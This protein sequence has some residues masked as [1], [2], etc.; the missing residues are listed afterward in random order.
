MA[1]E[2]VKQLVGEYRSFD[3]YLA[4]G[5]F[6]ALSQSQMVAVYNHFQ[7]S[8]K[9]DKPERRSTLVLDS[10]KTLDGEPIED[11]GIL[12]PDGSRACANWELDPTSFQVIN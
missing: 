7:H 12:Q 9:L 8:G 2:N 3:E 10:R 5:Q 6:A 1:L 4:S 11:R